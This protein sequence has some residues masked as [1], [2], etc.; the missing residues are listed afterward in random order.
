MEVL[1]KFI[2]LLIIIA[3]FAV[4]EGKFMTKDQVKAEF[5]KFNEKG[6]VSKDVLSQDALNRVKKFKLEEF[7][8]TKD[9]KS[10]LEGQNMVKG[11]VEIKYKAKGFVDRRDCDTPVVSQCGGVCTSHGLANAMDN[12]L[13]N[14]QQNISNMDLWNKYRKYSSASAIRAAKKYYVCE[15]KD[16]PN[17]GKRKAS[18]AKNRHV[19]LLESKALGNNVELAKRALDNGHALNYAGKVTRSW[20]NCDKVMNPKSAATKGGHAVSISG[21]RDDSSILGGGYFIIKNSWGKRCGDKG[22]Q[23]LPYQ[24]CKRNDKGMY[25]F[26]TEV[27][28]IESKYN[29]IEPVGPE[30]LPIPV[31]KKIKIC[32]RIW[33]TLWIKKK[34]TLKE[35]CK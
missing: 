9:Q 4:A 33:W 17:C 26:M 30:P 20:G 19:L 27:V 12:T 32:K 15:E 34:C 14:K 5:E 31:C 23:Y 7:E 35:I 13:C 1:M 8:L 10:F 2:V 16:F 18:C 11:F 3:S 29:S 21:Y 28:K 25:C 24:Y 22:Y 6:F